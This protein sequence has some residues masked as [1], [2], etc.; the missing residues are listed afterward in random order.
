MS[1]YDFSVLFP[2]HFIYSSLLFLPIF[3]I[4]LFRNCMESIS[5]YFVFVHRVIG[6]QQYLWDH[7]VRVLMHSMSGYP[8]SIA[9]IAS[10]HIM[11]FLKFL[12]PVCFV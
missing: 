5:S 7:L 8:D 10:F 2:A 1:V 12:S 3:I 4:F 11:V 9:I 6:E